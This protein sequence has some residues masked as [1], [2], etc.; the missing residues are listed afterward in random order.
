MLKVTVLLKECRDIQIRCGSSTKDIVNDT[1]AIVPFEMT[2]D[3][4]AEKVISERLVSLFIFLPEHDSQK[5][6][7]FFLAWWFEFQIFVFLD[8]CKRN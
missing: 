6:R 1:T 5:L 3:S 8:L 7:I 2:T 4:D